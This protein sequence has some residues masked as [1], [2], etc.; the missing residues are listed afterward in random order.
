MNLQPKRVKIYGQKEFL[1][2][3]VGLEFKT[4]GGVI[5]TDNF[6]SVAE[7]GFIKAGTAV[8]KD[9]EGIYQPWEDEAGAAGTAAGLTAEDV[10][11]E[12]GAKAIVGILL[13]GHPLE[14]R[15]TGVTEGFKEATAGYLRF[16]A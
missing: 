3:S 13:S 7:N 4:A 8:Y 11:A 10:R 9:E 1:R 2:N 15:C 16:D 14:E 12:A 5:E 6:A